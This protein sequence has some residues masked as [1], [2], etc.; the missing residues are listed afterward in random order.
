MFA[1][2]AGAVFLTLM[3]QFNSSSEFVL[4]TKT[5]AET[6]TQ[7]Q[8]DVLP[9]TSNSSST[10]PKYIRTQLWRDANGNGQVDNHEDCLPKQYAFKIGSKQYQAAQGANCSYQYTL[11]KSSNNCVEVRFVNT[12]SNYQFTAINYSDK[13]VTGKV[14]KSKSVTVCGFSNYGDGFG[15]AQVRFGVKAK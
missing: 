9:K 4:G 3:F 6:L 5:T 13:K 2:V 11:N 12:L 14:T 10:T 8:F 1:A 15:Y 7:A